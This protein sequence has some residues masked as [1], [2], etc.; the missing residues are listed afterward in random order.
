MQ[1]LAAADRF[2]PARLVVTFLGVDVASGI[3]A[4]GLLI[5]LS[6]GVLAAGLV[7]VFR[8]T[9]VI[10]IAHAQVGAFG[11]ALLAR[12]VIDGGVPW[13]V[14]LPVVL[15]VGAAVGAVVE[16]VVVRRLRDAPRVVLLVATLGVS[17]VLLVA[18]IALPNIS[19]PG[20]PY[21]L[22]FDRTVSFGGVLLDGSGLLTLGLVPAAVVVLALFLERTPT[23]LAIRASADNRDAAE[24]AGISTRRVS[25]LVWALA[26]ALAVMTV[27]LA[28]G[29]LR[30]RVGSVDVGLGPGLLLRALV[31]ALVGRLVS[32]PL[33]LIGGVVIGIVDALMQVNLP[34]DPGYV[35]A[36]LLVAVLVLVLYRALRD[37]RGGFSDDA[38]L[39]VLAP[40]K[41]VPEAVRDLWWVRRLGALT[42]GAALLAAVAVPALGLS[43]GSLAAASR[44]PLF[45]IVGLSLVVLTGWA[46]QLSLGQIALFGVGAFSASALVARGVPFP[47]AV[48]EAT[49]LGVLVALVVGLPALLVRGLFL[50]ITTLAF[51][52]AASSAVFQSAFLVGEAG[53][54]T[55]EPGRLLGL[56]LRDG[57]TY[58]YLCLA[59]LALCGLLVTA[60]RRS[61]IGRTII[62]VRSNSDRA[63]SLTVSPTLALL[64]AFGLSGGLAA[65]AGAL[66]AGL[67]RTVTYTQ[68]SLY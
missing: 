49:V 15:V 43:A 14:A 5:G 11:A 40:E 13:A 42:W 36:V 66:F 33:A 26:G 63:A 51:A 20:L 21:P 35:D 44:V 3:V 29:L 60:L 46:G 67:Q 56:D 7:L 17:Q 19:V 37:G 65:F 9:R 54:A 52:V 27:V 2:L 24:L 68:F 61:G 57:P 62:A 47:A 4:I 39:A 64:T 45:A 12:M 22:P 48:L 55:L 18:E 23:G 25:T 1:V 32:L 34:S 6:Y 58:Y 50:A 30:T 53:V 8:A 38:S 28:N 31:A 10:N 16:L 41:P 59:A